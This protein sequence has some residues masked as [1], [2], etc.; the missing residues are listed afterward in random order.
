MIPLCMRLKISNQ[1]KRNVSLWL[2]LFL[3]WL[4]VI[5]L[6]IILLPIVLLT[7]LFLWPRGLGGIVLIGYGMLFVILWS[8]SG[9]HL[10]IGQS[11]KEVCVTLR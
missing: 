2:P 10:E 7:A 9:F 6:M 8:L 3:A 1:H 5:P 4:I 11:D